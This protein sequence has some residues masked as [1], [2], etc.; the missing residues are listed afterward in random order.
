[1]PLT[2]GVGQV[3]F[4]IRCILLLRSVSP[5]KVLLQAEITIGISKS[6]GPGK[7]REQNQHFFTKR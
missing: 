5:L 6:L 3:K 1:M 2:P 4:D 7:V